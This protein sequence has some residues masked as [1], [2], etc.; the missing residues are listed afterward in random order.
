MT[1][2]NN[3]LALNDADVLT[4]RFESIVDATEEDT[5]YA[6]S[7]LK[8]LIEANTIAINRITNLAAECEHPRA[9]EVLG[10]LVK[11]SADMN[12]QLLDLQKK[13]K[14]IVMPK[15][16][17]TTATA[18]VDAP[19]TVNN[20]AVFVGTTKDLQDIIKQTLDNGGDAAQELLLEA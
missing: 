12:K 6:R 7:E 4:D 13:R 2:K 16:P 5:E 20:T 3:E 14:D 10:Q 15:E 19:Q 18:T 17:S 11:L 9:F 8:R 1:K